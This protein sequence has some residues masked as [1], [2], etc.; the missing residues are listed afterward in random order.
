VNELE[1]VRARLRPQEL[2]LLETPEVQRL[3]PAEQ[4]AYLRSN[5]RVGAGVTAFA[6]GVRLLLLGGGAIAMIVYALGE[7]LGGRVFGWLE[8]TAAIAGNGLLAWTVWMA[9]ALTRRL[10]E[11]REPL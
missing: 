11:L 4:V 3:S 5:R 8:I 1:A 6:G 9:I 2:A 7:L 10:K